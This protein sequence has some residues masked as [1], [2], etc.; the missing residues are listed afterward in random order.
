MPFWFVAG[1]AG[2]IAVALYAYLRQGTRRDQLEDLSLCKH[3]LV[4]I[5]LWVLALAGCLLLVALATW[6]FQP[7]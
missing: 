4:L 7:R 2:I 6:A 1:I 3:C 5:V